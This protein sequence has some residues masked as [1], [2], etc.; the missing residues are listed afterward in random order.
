MTQNQLVLDSGWTLSLDAQ[1]K[2]S[3][4]HHQG[5]AHDLHAV[6]YDVWMKDVVEICQNNDK[7]LLVTQAGEVVGVIC[8]KDILQS[9]LRQAELNS[10]MPM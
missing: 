10:D 4:L 6:D 9:L 5:Q 7:P 1:G 3:T 2:V 8:H